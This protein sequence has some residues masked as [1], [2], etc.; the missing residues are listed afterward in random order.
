VIAFLV[1]SAYA[2]THGQGWRR[3][4]AFLFALRTPQ[5]AKVTPEMA[6]Q[7][8][9]SCEGC[10]IYYK[11]L[12]TCG[13]PLDAQLRDDDGHPLGCNCFMPYKVKLPCNC[14]IYDRS[15]GNSSVWRRDLNSFPIKPYEPQ[16]IDHQLEANR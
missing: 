10:P 3:F 16:P 5:G 7:R 1:A 2:V 6:R 4:R 9:E 13:S 14:W 11:A 8:L 12:M 15:Q